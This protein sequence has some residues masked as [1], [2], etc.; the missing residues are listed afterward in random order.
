MSMAN[1]KCKD[2]CLS[3]LVKIMQGN[4]WR[5]IRQHLVLPWN[6]HHGNYMHSFCPSFYQN[7]L[8]MSF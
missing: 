5:H 7:L 3:F 2:L 4:A 1:L 8:L 6:H